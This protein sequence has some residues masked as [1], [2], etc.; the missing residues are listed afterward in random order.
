MTMDIGTLAV[1]MPLLFLLFGLSFT[2]VIDPYIRREHRR[3]MLVIAVLCLTLIAQDYW[4]YALTVG[5]PR[6]MLRTIV[7]IYGYS[8]RPVILILFLYIVQPTGK[9]WYW[10]VLAGLNAAVY[11]TAFF[12]LSV[13]GSTRRTIITA[14]RLPVPVSLP[15]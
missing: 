6:Q 3:T 2:V 8:I 14:G 15:A 13:F 9:R 11:L 12:P 5:S 7:T 1:L 4:D 10:W